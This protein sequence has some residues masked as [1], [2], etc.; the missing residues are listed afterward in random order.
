MY[1][2]S[3][4]RIPEGYTMNEF[5]I[6]LCKDI[7]NDMDKED[8]MDKLFRM[9]YPIMLT[10]LKKYTNFGPLDEL[11]P[12]LS[13]AFMRTIEKFDP[14]NPNASFINYYKQVLKTTILCN[15]YGKY[16]NNEE[17]RNLKK[18][19]E[20]TIGSLDDPLYNK[21]GIE[22]NSWYDVIEDKNT[23]IE[24][25][26]LANDYK[27]TIQRIINKIFDKKGKGRSEKST[28]PKA[29]FTDYVESILD[30]EGLTQVDL[31]KKYDIGRSGINK[32]I[33][34]YMPRFIKELKNN[35]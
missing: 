14:D 10:E 12:D 11:S 34:T 23:N 18:N 32:T 3:A 17:S 15:Y 9:T 7:R 35:N 21:D 19:F 31:S 4:Y 1:E 30:D 27:Y 24:E 26:I 33:T 16:K 28:R 20:N 2:V 13:L 5:A 25:E 8:A 29:V 6:K 22:T